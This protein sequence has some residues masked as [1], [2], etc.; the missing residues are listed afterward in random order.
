LR[1]RGFEAHSA[2]EAG[3]LNQGATVQ[4]AHAVEH[5]MAI[6]T[7]NAD[8]FLALAHLYAD[9]GRP[10]AGIIVPVCGY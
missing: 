1:D 6:L 2:A 8:H 5:D 7:C 3:L 9:T 4:L 10:H